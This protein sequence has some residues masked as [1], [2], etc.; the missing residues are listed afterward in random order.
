MMT[1]LASDAQAQGDEWTAKNAGTTEVSAEKRFDEARLESWMAANVEGFEGPL[2]VR[3]F[4]GGQSNPTFKLF[5]PGRTY[6]MRRKPAG[7]L[8]RSAHAVDREYRALA[9][10]H[11]TGF[12]VARPFA[13]CTDDSVIGSWFYIMD[14][15]E[16]RIF[17][18]TSFPDVAQ[19]DRPAYFAA[20]NETLA[21]LHS[22]RPEDVG[23]GDYG[24]PG[25]YFQ[26]QIGR[27]TKQYLEDEIAGRNPHMDKLIEWLPA[28]IPAG[29]EV[30]IVHG[31][32][33]C[34]NMIFHPTEPKVIAVLDWELSTLGHP[35]ADFAFHAMMYRMPPA[36]TTGLVGIDIASMNIPSEEDYLALYCRNSGR[37][38][39]P[40]FD[41]YV[42]FNMFRLAAIIH[43]IRG[44]ALRG[45]A[46]SSH[47]LETAK[48]LEPLAELA[49]EQA[50]RA[51]KR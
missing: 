3:Q 30:S 47:A 8:V 43:G 7:L 28:N 24:K 49:W 14:C 20:M 46:S 48:R 17:W 50:L 51:D 21:R 13:L 11:P 18:D 45:T 44:R 42:A 12:P 26:R 40:D 41:F 4:K 35:L 32:Y 1:E 16:G 38:S 39:I 15:V 9:A 19:A 6:V 36:I 29:E 10:L 27:F 2:T 33:R 31:D 37:E 25:N 22:I 34:D 5:T 23:M